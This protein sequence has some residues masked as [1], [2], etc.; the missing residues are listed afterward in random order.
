MQK[1]NGNL[2]MVFFIFFIFV[3]VGHAKSCRYW[4]KTHDHRYYCCPS[5]KSES[6]HGMSWPT[7]SIPWFWFNFGESHWHPFV[8]SPWEK[9][10]AKKHCPPLRSHCPRSYDWYDMPTFCDDDE[11]CH[12]SSDKCCYDVCLEHKTCKPAE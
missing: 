12:H 3:Y 2:K 10:K 6:W 7:F 5:G 4:C 8:H 1:S 9:K 11:D